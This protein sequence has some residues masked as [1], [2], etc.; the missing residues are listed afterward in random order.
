MNGKEISMSLNEKQLN[1][2]M[3]ATACDTSLSHIYNVAYRTT[4]SRPIAEKIA[5][6]IGKPFAEVFPDYVAKMRA[7]QQQVKR[8]ENLAKIVNQ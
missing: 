5:L 7:K 3:L 4:I 1:F 6:A 2:S 8:I